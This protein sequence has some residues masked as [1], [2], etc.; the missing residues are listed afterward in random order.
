MLN[1]A[2]GQEG[3]PIK[4]TVVTSTQEWMYSE[5]RV[6]NVSDRVVTRVTLGMTLSPISQSGHVETEKGILIEGHPISTG[7]LQPQDETTLAMHLISAS[8]LRERR[9]RLGW[10]RSYAEIGVLKASYEG[11]EYVFDM[12]AHHGFDRAPIELG[13]RGGL[14]VPC[15]GRA[16]DPYARKSGLLRAAAFAGAAGDGLETSFYCSS[17]PTACVYFTNSYTSCTATPCTG[18]SCGSGTCRESC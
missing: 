5:V 18:G 17:N 9:S 4:F 16:R 1:F 15:K 6:R 11:G 14:M 10:I 7:G 3:S 8:D 12:T 13:P 2:I